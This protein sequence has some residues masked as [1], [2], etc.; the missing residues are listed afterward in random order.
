MTYLNVK[1]GLLNYIHQ[2]IIEKAQG[3][4][5]FLLCAGVALLTPKLDEMYHQYKEHPVIK[6]LGVI[7]DNDHIDVDVLYDAMKHAINKV[8]KVELM[9]IIFNS[10]DID[11]LYSHIKTLD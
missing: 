8:G 1:N 3:T 6:A 4:N 9:G 10:S 2:E 7:H 11:S 5:K